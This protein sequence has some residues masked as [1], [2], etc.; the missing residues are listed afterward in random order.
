[1]NLLS[2]AERLAALDVAPI[3]LHAERCV[4]ARDKSATCDAC[5]RACPT[6]ALHLNGSITLNAEVCQVCGACLPV[7]PTGAFEGDDGVHDLLN[8]VSRLEPARSIELACAQHPA[9]EKGSATVD[10]VVSTTTCLAA[11]GPSAYVGLI[12]L[13][14]QRVAVRLDACATCPLGKAHASIVETLDRTRQLLRL[15]GLADRIIAIT[16]VIDRQT[17]SVYAAKNPPLSRRGLFHLFA[18]EGPRQIAR[19]L[20]DDATQLSIKSPSLERRRLISALRHLPAINTAASLGDGP[21]AHFTASETCTACDVCERICPTGALHLIE[22]EGS[23]YQLTFNSAACVACDACVQIC[24]PAALTH[25][26]ATLGEL[27][28][29]ETVVLRV[30]TLRA[31]TKCGAKFAAATNQEL[32]PMCDF[33]QTNP[34]GGRLPASVL[35]RRVA[36]LIIPKE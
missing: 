3:R 32:C 30:G 11:L 26:T 17:R 12:V 19:V 6:A 22:G 27:L 28:N 16:T 25:E 29:A 33:R 5:V 4:H 13:G 14:M 20:S 18:A 31:C 8:C 2:L 1:M 9:P 24:E 10:A 34:F 23:M 15:Y 21:F 35:R 36:T 7:C